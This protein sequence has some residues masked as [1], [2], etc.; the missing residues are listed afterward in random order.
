MTGRRALLLMLPLLITAG[1]VPAPAQAAVGSHAGGSAIVHPV[2][3]RR[4]EV[5][6]SGFNARNAA[7]RTVVVTAGHCGEVG[8]DWY[9]R[10]D[11][12]RLGTVRRARNTDDP[13]GDD[14]DYAVISNAGTYRLPP[15]IRDRGVSKVVSRVG[16]PT[17]GLRVCFTGRTSGTRCGRITEVR[18]NGVVITSMAPRQ[19][20]SGGPLFSRVAGTDR[21]RAIG[22]VVATDGSRGYH[23]RISEVLREYHLRLKTG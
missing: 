1:P 19:G 9:A 23:Q 13:Q 10:E 22:I 12:P 3:P 21:V 7:G 6:S 16:R 2:N 4:V 11:G 5:C 17:R 8:S 15:R 18:R 20:D 14:D